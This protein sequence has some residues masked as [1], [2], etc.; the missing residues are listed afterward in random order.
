MRGAPGRAARKLTRNW[1]YDRTRWSTDGPAR[2]WLAKNI[3]RRQAAGRERRRRFQGACHRG[4]SFSAAPKKHLI[5]FPTSPQVRYE[6][7]M[8]GQA[9]DHVPPAGTLAITPAGSDSSG[10]AVGNADLILVAIEPGISHGVT[11]TVAS[12]GGN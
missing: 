6:C 5:W 12:C 1:K 11:T 3:C 4:L 9:V 10:D 8:A 2:W 7:R